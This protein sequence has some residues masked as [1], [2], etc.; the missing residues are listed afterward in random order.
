[1]ILEI[2]REPGFLLMQ[3]DFSPAFGEW[4]ELIKK[5]IGDKNYENLM[6]RF[7]TTTPLA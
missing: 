5:H 3:Q 7:S 4:C 2:A 6:P 1:M